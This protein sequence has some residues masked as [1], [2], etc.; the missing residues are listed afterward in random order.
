MSKTLIQIIEIN[1]VEEAGNILKSIDFEDDI[2]EKAKS[3]IYADTSENRKLG[4]VGQK[5]GNKKVDDKKTKAIK[6]SNKILSKIG[7]GI[8]IQFSG[9]SDSNGISVY[10]KAIKADKEVKIRFS[11]HSVTNIN[12]IQN[13]IHFRFNM[14]ESLIQNSINQ[15]KFE[16]GIKGYKYG[17]TKLIMPSGKLSEVFGF[18]KEK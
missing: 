15:I 8:K 11:D 14:N 12:R 18:Y 2:F 16:L 9:Y 3:G 6:F 7:D 4:R 5:Y 13:E 17:K 10:Y 1:S